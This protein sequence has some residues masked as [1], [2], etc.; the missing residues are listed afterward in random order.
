MSFPRHK[1][2]WI[3]LATRATGDARNQ[4]YVELEGHKITNVKEFYKSI[5]GRAGVTEYYIYDATNVR[6]RELS[7]G[8]NLPQEWLQKTG[9]FKSIQISMIARNLCFLYN[10]AP[11]DPDLVL[12]TGND[13]QAIDSYGMPTTRNYGFNLR[14]TF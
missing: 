13:N 7:L 6:I 5:G 3:N 14:F 8:Y 1:P 2:I 10:K 12:S 11:F 4:G 9:V